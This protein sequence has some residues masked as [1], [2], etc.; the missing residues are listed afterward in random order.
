MSDPLSQRGPPKGKVV[1]L[2]VKFLDDS[3][4][5]FQ[6]TIKGL[7]NVLWEAVVRYLQ[8]VESDYFDLQYDDTHGVRC[9]LDHEK[10]LLK[11]LPSPDSPLDF[12]V[13]FYTPDPGL[14]DEFT[15]Y[16]FALQVKKDLSVGQMVCSENT[17]ALL[18]SY[19]VQAE[20]GDYIIEEYIDHTYLMSMP[21]FIPRQSEGLLK[22]V[23]EYHKQHIGE[24]PA[25]A[26]ASLV[27]VA[28][29]VET[30]GIRLNAAKDHE[31]VALYLAVAHMGILVFQN[32]TKI[33]TFS[34]AKI[35]KLSFKRKK[36]LIKLHPD[37]YGYYKDT[38]EFF[39][40]SRDESKNFWKQCIEHHAFFRCHMIK[41]IP[42]NKTK[43]VSRGSSFR[44][45]GRTQKQLMTYVRETCVKS[46][47]F[48]RSTSGRISSA[49]RSTSVT[50]KIS[51]KMTLNNS[52]DTH[53]STAS[54]GSHILS[55]GADTP[56]DRTEVVDVHSAGSS[57]SGSRSLG[58]P[59]PEHS[60]TPDGTIDTKAYLVSGGEEERGAHSN[61]VITNAIVV[62]NQNLSSNQNPTDISDLSLTGGGLSSHM[63]TFNQ[64]ENRIDKLNSDL[65][66]IEN[67][68]DTYREKL[69]SSL[70]RDSKK[71]VFSPELGKEESSNESNG[72]MVQEENQSS[73][74]IKTFTDQEHDLQAET[75]REIE[76]LIASVQEEKRRLAEGDAKEKTFII[77]LKE[78]F[79]AGSRISVSVGVS[80]HQNSPVKHIEPD[81]A[82][83]MSQDSIDFHSTDIDLSAQT[84]IDCDSFSFSSLANSEDLIDTYILHRRHFSEELDEENDIISPVEPNVQFNSLRRS[85]SLKKKRPTNI[86]VEQVKVYAGSEDGSPSPQQHQRSFSCGTK[87]SPH[88]R[89]PSEKGFSILKSRSPSGK[90]TPGGHSQ[91][92]L[93][94]SPS[95][96]K[97]RNYFTLPPRDTFS[98]IDDTTSPVFETDI[99]KH[100]K[101]QHEKCD[102]ILS[103]DLE[104]DHARPH[105]TSYQSKEFKINNDDLKEM[106]T[107]EVEESSILDQSSST[108]KSTE[109]TEI[110]QNAN[111]KSKNGKDFKNERSKSVTKDSSKHSKLQ[112]QSVIKTKK[113]QESFMSQTENINGDKQNI[114]QKSEKAKTII[115]QSIN[116]ETVDF[117]D[118]QLI[119]SDNGSLDFPSPAAVYL[120]S[121][122]KYLSKSN[123]S[124]GGITFTTFKPADLSTPSTPGSRPISF[125]ESDKGD[126]TVSLLSSATDTL[127]RTCKIPEENV[128]QPTARKP[129]LNHRQSSK[130]MPN[131]RTRRKVSFPRERGYKYSFESVHDP[132]YLSLAPSDDFNLDEDSRKPNP[133]LGYMSQDNS[134]MIESD[135]TESSNGETDPEIESSDDDRHDEF[136]KFAKSL[137]DSGKETTADSSVGAEIECSNGNIVLR[138][139]SPLE[140][141][142]NL[143]QANNDTYDISIN[144]NGCQIKIEIDE[145]SSDSEH[146]IINRNKRC[147]VDPLE[148]LENL[149]IAEIEISSS[150]SSEEGRKKK[151]KKKS[152]S[153]LVIP[154]LTVSNPSSPDENNIDSK[155]NEITSHSV[156]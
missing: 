12:C 47:S 86:Q 90:R 115:D 117:V 91:T 67:V 8:L 14:L 147:S 59:K 138:E 135:T 120:L 131:I 65:Y 128:F 21:P 148:E 19:I 88:S 20:L 83:P 106:G 134:E 84:S 69:Y 93:D 18:A 4:H 140:A 55:T 56:H 6:I 25:E 145:S 102:T 101:D 10:G 35:R 77:D 98:S 124:S 112:K 154:M 78:D 68:P 29:K 7:G 92:S 9:W 81:L 144:K 70:G 37:T 76:N 43:L 114:E 152:R 121:E 109:N 137:A 61:L 28:R 129:K 17:A 116:D 38:V 22:K 44:Y 46:P 97:R 5:A 49:S 23:M 79:P 75:Q 125:V 150:S 104:T 141:L 45:S 66:N 11:Q 130:D 95:G 123:R 51:A 1:N 15:R 52:T 122:G 58:S 149:D 30:Y 80:S 111:K 107:N 100:I 113:E 54:S 60:S 74:N 133:F 13:K 64:V 151:T 146:E 16:L 103:T 85:R 153:K 72:R 94:M 87:R 82:S 142:D 34:W 2:R 53:N 3:V 39:F 40:E 27:D 50:P 26:E 89:S 110:E 31:G 156:C 32:N 132:P 96:G 139:S 24:T 62:H 33:N 119:A 57:L 63:Y 42:R 48:Q 127:S 71:V 105:L 41:K 136:L 99:V 143:D 118:S 73:I 108:D 126:D 155:Y 36:F